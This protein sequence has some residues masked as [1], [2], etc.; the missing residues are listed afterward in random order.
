MKK[1]VIITLAFML[2]MTATALVSCTTNNKDK[3]EGDS[4]ANAESV[5]GATDNVTVME[6]SAAQIAPAASEVIDNQTPA[7]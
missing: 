7:D 3:I 4:A 5:V 2:S 6:E 1:K